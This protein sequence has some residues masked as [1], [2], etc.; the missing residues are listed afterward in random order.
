M[1]RRLILATLSFLAL[2][3]AHLPLS[4]QGVSDAEAA[5]FQ[6]VIASHPCTPVHTSAPPRDQAAA[7]TRSRVT[8]HGATHD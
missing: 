1:T 5:E 2:L 3:G 7:S 8:R 4:A 6:R